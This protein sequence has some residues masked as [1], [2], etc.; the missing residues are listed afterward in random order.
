[1]RSTTRLAVI[2]YVPDPVRDE[3]RNVGVIA[4]RAGEVAARFVG[5]D[6]AGDLDRR[7]ISRRLIEDRQTYVEWVHYWRTQ[8]AARSIHD[9]VEDADV[10]VGE[11][12]F[13]Q[14]LA[15]ATRGGFEVRSRGEVVA[16]DD[17]DLR[18]IVGE[19]FE[20]LVEPPDWGDTDDEEE[21]IGKA[22]HRK[23]AW[24]ACRAL[25]RHHYQEKRD[26]VRDFRVTGETGK[27]NEVPAVFDIG[28]RAPVDLVSQGELLLVDAVS[29]AAAPN[30]LSDVVDRA[31][32]VATKAQETRQH[33]DR[34]FV[35]A[36]VSNG[37][38]V[39]SEAGRYA[40]RILQDDGD[41]ELVT[42]EQLLTLVPRIRQGQRL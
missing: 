5:E 12:G 41:L 29:L 23:L 19:S 24:N 37:K 34:V 15:N 11:A 33:H 38:S 6:D 35:R 10:A 36:L 1:M 26:F 30:Q 39:E 42:I 32:A 7:H 4:W 14:A 18:R 3:P 25:M 28:V 9:P 31:R 2:R 16:A 17:W 27:G 13:L 40:T 20:R 21:A 22:H 8:L